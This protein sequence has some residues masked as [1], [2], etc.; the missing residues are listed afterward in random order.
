MRPNRE[1]PCPRTASQLGGNYIDGLDVANFVLNCGE[2]ELVDL[3][4]DLSVDH[5]EDVGSSQE[6]LLQK[7]PQVLAE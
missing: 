5:V 6:L 7:C 4:F 1:Y 2:V 3:F